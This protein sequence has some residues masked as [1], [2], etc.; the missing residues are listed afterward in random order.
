MKP[1][2]SSSNDGVSIE[3]HV[4]PGASKSGWSGAFGDRLKLRIS[5]KAVDGQANESLIAFLSKFLN[6]PKSHVS[7]TRGDKSREKTVFVSGDPEQI[8][9]KLNEVLTDREDA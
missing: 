7:I 8:A 5:G 4:Q 6:V 9:A 3:L 1:F 2:Y